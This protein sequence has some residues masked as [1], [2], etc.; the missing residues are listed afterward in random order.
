LAKL[1][2]TLL[3]LRLLGLL[4]VLRLV[5]SAAAVAAQLAWQRVWLLMAVDVQTLMLRLLLRLLQRMLLLELLGLALK[6][7]TLVPER[8][9]VLPASALS[10]AGM[11]PSGGSRHVD[12]RSRCNPGLRPCPPR[13]V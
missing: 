3:L 13:S 8:R 11:P 12:E 10:S 2:Q 5:V 1:A 9:V 6:H 4:L 7:R